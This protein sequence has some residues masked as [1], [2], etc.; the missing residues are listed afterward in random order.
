MQSYGLQ[1][2]CSGPYDCLT[3]TMLGDFL[4]NVLNLKDRHE[5][6]Q[7]PIICKSVSMQIVKYLQ[8][9]NSFSVEKV[10]TF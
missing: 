1:Q 3:F 7:K 9:T 6:S 8:A 2:R 4:I 10:T 5:F